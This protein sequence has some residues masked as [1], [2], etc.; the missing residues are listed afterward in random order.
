MTRRADQEANAAA[1]NG[2]ALPLAGNGRDIPP[3]TPPIPPFDFADVLGAGQSFAEFSRIVADY[4]EQIGMS[5]ATLDAE[6]FIGS[7][8]AAKALAKRARKKLGWVTWG[9]VLAAIG[10]KFYL[11]RDPAAP[12]HA[13]SVASR[14]GNGR[15]QHWRNVKGST[16]GRRMA[17]LRALKLPAERRSEIARKAAQVRHR[18]SVAAPAGIANGSAVAI[19]QPGTQDAVA[20]PAATLATTVS[21]PAPASARQRHEAGQLSLFGA[22]NGST[23]HT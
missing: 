6:A 16:W 2:A 8:H 21:K 19:P 17:A 3:C 5:R 9:R 13:S 1:P 4:C 20:A 23:N 10:V 14:N 18:G 12:I 11:V 7:G 15:E 22:G